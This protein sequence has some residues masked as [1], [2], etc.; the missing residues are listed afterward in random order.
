MKLYSKRTVL[1]FISTS[2]IE[3]LS[4]LRMKGVHFLQW[5][6]LHPNCLLK[7]PQQQSRPTVRFISDHFRSI[8]REQRRRLP[9]TNKNGA[10]KQLFERI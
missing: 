7:S 10:A 9:K 6:F 5:S 1:Y 8:E 2:Q 3:L 4:A